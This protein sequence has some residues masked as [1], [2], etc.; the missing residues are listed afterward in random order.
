MP[1]AQQRVRRGKSGAACTRKRGGAGRESAHASFHSSLTEG[2]RGCAKLVLATGPGIGYR[3]T[4]ADSRSVF[5]NVA[6]NV[7]SVRADPGA[8][9]G[10]I[11]QARAAGGAVAA[12]HALPLA[13]AITG[14]S[15]PESTPHSFTELP[16]ASVLLRCTRT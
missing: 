8:L 15:G 9:V 3:D 11:T 2:A 5:P 4:A 6:H 14:Y 7:V 12:A 10:V 1:A 16:D 13:V